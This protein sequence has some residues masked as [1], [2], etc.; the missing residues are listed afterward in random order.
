MPKGSL[1]QEVLGGESQRAYKITISAENRPFGS[2]AIVQKYRKVTSR[3]S[4]TPKH[5]QN[6]FE[7]EFF[8]DFK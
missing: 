4:S 3:V 8:H 7:G 1:N 2:Q 6:V 5:F